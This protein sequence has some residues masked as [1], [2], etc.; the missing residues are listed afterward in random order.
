MGY[1]TSEV[2][3]GGGVPKHLI[4][5]LVSR[6]N[7]PYFIETGSGGGDSARLAAQY[8]KEVYTIEL[9]GERQNIDKENENIFWYQG[10]SHENLL[11][12]IYKLRN[13]NAIPKNEM[14]YAVFYLDAHYDGDK[15]ID[16]K[17]KDCYLIDE[18]NIIGSEY[19]ENAI[20]IIDDARLFLGH[21][22]APNDP[23]QW[24]TI[25]EIFR[26]FD[27]FYEYHIVTLR[28]DYIIAY[29][30]RVQDVFNEEWRSKFHLRYPDEKRVVKN[31]ARTTFANIKKYLE[32]ND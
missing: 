28:D 20:Y 23:R 22:P 27:E 14:P 6:F 9:R 2:V 15:P 3:L 18:L 17:D 32:S 24:P 12:I 1:K 16:S 13:G 5:P 21:P 10:Y 29:P 25:Q 11:K 26:K 8:F 4:K 7:I 31:A 30:D 19:G